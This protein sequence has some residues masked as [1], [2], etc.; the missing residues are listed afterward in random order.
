M[1][2][3][4]NTLLLLGP[5]TNRLFR[6]SVKKN[7]SNIEYA[8]KELRGDRD[9][10]MSSV[11]L[12]GRNLQSASDEM[13]SKRD[14]VM[15]AVSSSGFALKWANPAFRDDKDVVL[16]AVKND[17]SA[18]QFASPELRADSDVV[19]EA[20]DKDSTAIQWANVKDLAVHASKFKSKKS[21]KE[22]F[23]KAQNEK[24][25]L[26][27]AIK[28][29]CCALRGAPDSIKDDEQMVL[30]ALGYN[31]QNFKY[32]S[33]RV[34]GK[35]IVALAAVEASHGNIYHIPRGLLMDRKFLSA[36]ANAARK[37]LLKRAKAEL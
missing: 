25:I 30:E 33:E 23:A 20:V 31:Y 34:R 15:A 26:R 22:P 10:V 8:S 21:S 3:R 28:I 37:G 14:I 36:L 18:L 11:E 12:D 35:K 2:L 29:D 17:S 13:R 7:P 4:H 24:D 5:E 19:G 9:V 1:T 6:H 27:N 32:A 16:C